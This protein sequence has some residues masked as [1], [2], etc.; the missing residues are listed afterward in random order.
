MILH[1]KGQIFL[2]IFLLVIPAEY[3]HWKK[4]KCNNF[5]AD[6]V[7]LVLYSQSRGVPK[8]WSAICL[9][10]HSPKRPDP[11]L[12]AG[13]ITLCN[14]LETKGLAEQN[15]SE[16]PRQQTAQPCMPLVNQQQHPQ[17]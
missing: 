16:K 17:W 3:R 15:S 13:I 1:K 11:A 14:T 9:Q 4:M 2:F 8:L 12:R 6:A 7:C 5:F 10:E